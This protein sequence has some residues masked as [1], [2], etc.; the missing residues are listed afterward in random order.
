MCTFC[1]SIK[2]SDGFSPQS[3]FVSFEWLSDYT[4]IVSPNNINR[5]SSYVNAGNDLRKMLI[6]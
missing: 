3:V 2:T 4:V 5:G 6:T 1:F